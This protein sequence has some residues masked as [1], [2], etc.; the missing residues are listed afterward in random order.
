MLI[1]LR[2]TGKTV[3][4]IGGGVEATRKIQSFL[5]SEAK[6]WVISRDFTSELQKLGEE[7]RVALLKTGIKDAQVFVDSLSPKPYVLLAA[8]NNPALNLELVKAAKNY[9]CIVYA[10]DNPELNDFILPAV[11]HVGDVKIAVST[12]GKSPAMAH[13]LRERVEKMVTP[14]DL[15]AIQ[16]QEKARAALKGKVLDQKERSKILYE[17]LNSEGIK[18]AL[19]EGKTAE[20]EELAIQLI[21]KGANQT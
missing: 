5:E 9:G 4:V 19:S 11:A 3:M 21:E 7:K 8:T 14:Q 18:K 10:I 15:L 12:G 16:L 20:A 17:I 1:D 6:I 13:V 2:L